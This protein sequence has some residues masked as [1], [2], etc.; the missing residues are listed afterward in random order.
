MR[1]STLLW[2]D[3][4]GFF[5]LYTK[6]FSN[7]LNTTWVFYNL[8]L[9]LSI[10]RQCQITRVKAQSNKMAHLSQV[11]GCDLCFWQTSYQSWFLTPS[12]RVWWFTKMAH[13]TQEHF[14]YIYQFI[15]M[16]TDGQRKRYRGWGWEQSRAQKLY[17]WWRWGTA[18]MHSLTES[19]SN[20]LFKRFFEV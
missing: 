9:I 16:D 3:N 11:L 1:H 18:W 4:L 7:S 17:F 12:P 8:I 10:W 15:I 19:S 20:L 14:I 5:P 13:T 2:P 6:Q